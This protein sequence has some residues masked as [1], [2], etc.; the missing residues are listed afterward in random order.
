MSKG[1]ETGKMG[2]KVNE[3]FIQLSRKLFNKHI[4]RNTNELF[5]IVLQMVYK[6]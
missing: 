2:P 3:Y 4:S 1:R 6:M 5:Y